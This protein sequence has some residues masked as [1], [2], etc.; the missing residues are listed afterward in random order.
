MKLLTTLVIAAG[1]ASSSAAL[2]DTAKAPPAKA[3]AKAPPNDAPAK[4]APKADAADADVAKFLV[5]FDKLVDIAVAD[6]DDCKKMAA[7]VNAHIDLNKPILD[8]AKEAQAKGLKLPDTA[9][10]HMMQSAGKLMGAMQK[11]GNDKDVN[12]AFAKLP[13]AKAPGRPGK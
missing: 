5:F 4:D 2:A 7:D 6:K 3:P 13:S 9:R 11:C 10:E 12:A 1:L 8:K